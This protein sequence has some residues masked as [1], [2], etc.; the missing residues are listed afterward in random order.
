MATTRLTKVQ[1]FALRGSLEK[2]KEGDMGKERSQFMLQ[3]DC[4]VE[5]SAGHR[6]AGKGWSMVGPPNK[7]Y[8]SMFL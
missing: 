7:P 1:R 6:R 2:R 5:L 4:Q 3:A 8:V